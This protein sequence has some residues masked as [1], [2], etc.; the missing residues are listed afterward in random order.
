MSTGMTFDAVLDSLDLPSLQG[1]TTYWRSYPPVHVMVA[2]YMGIEPEARHSSK[3]KAND[4][5]VIAGLMS[6]FAQT[7]GK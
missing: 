2:A 1:F 6:A 5:S 7:P 4:D 3:P